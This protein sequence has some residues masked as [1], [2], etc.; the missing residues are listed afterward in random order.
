VYGLGE[1]ISTKETGE[2]TVVRRRPETTSEQPSVNDDGG[3]LDVTID[4]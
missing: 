1:I 3:S 2:S 4:L